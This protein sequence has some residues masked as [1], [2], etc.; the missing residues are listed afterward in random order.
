[1]LSYRPHVLLSGANAVGFDGGWLRESAA[2]DLRSVPR[3]HDDSASADGSDHGTSP[4]PWLPAANDGFAA[5]RGPAT[6]YGAAAAWHESRLGSSGHELQTCDAARN[7]AAR[8]DAEL[9]GAAAFVHGSAESPSP[10]SVD[11]SLSVVHEQSSCRRLRH[12]LR[13]RECP[14]L[15]RFL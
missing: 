8:R 9:L 14:S 13:R 10:S 15:R 2:A 11:R 7:D 6:A 12:G 4:G 5:L 1:M 3:S